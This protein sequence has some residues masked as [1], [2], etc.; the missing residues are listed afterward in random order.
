MQSESDQVPNKI[1][2][3]L[4]CFEAGDVAQAETLC[5]QIKKDDADHAAALRLLG[6]I[7]L[8]NRAYAEA[9]SLLEQSL[10]LDEPQPVCHAQLGEANRALGNSAKARFHY[11]RALQLKPDFAEIHNN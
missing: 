11:E 6:A 8:Q 2:R 9:A 3:A 4:Q 7:R 5:R 1:T 10:A